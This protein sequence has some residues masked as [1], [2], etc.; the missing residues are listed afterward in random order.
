MGYR[1][2]EE[3]RPDYKDIRV[4]ESRG[5]NIGERLD[6]MRRQI[7]EE[8]KAKAESWKSLIQDPVESALGSYERAQNR[9]ILAEEAAQKRRVADLQAKRAEQ[10]IAL[11]EEFG[12]EERQAQL[13]AAREQ[14]E[15][16][17]IAREQ[18]E[19]R[20]TLLG[21]TVPGT[22]RTYL[23]E[24]ILAP[25]EAQ[26]AQIALSGRQADLAEKQAGLAAETAR[27]NQAMGRLQIDNAE[28][29]RRVED[30]TAQLAVETDP[31]RRQA[32][33]AELSKT[34]TA[35]E[36]AQA[37][38]QVKSAEFQSGMMKMLLPT[39][40]NR[41]VRSQ[42]MQEQI[43]KT[44]SVLSDLQT[45]LKLLK[46]A[47]PGSEKA[48]AIA[49]RMAERA[50]SLGYEK[51]A[52]DLLKNFTFNPSALL[53]QRSPIQTRESNAQ[54][55]INM[56]KRKE[57]ENIRATYSDIP[58]A[59][60]YANSLNRQAYNLGVQLHGGNMFG[61]SQITNQLPPVPNIYDPM[62]QA[63]VQNA[64][65]EPQFQKTPMGQIQLQ[66]PNAQVQ[67]NPILEALMQGKARQQVGQK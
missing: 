5:P 9:R 7:A 12:R 66:Q 54:E 6:Q 45:D 62:R 35:P 17:R 65:T 18:A 30:M 56:I 38:S 31:T 55:I 14:M 15:T 23:Q 42:Q 29:A 57:S 36:I 3:Y 43:T 13:D 10:E 39:E 53:Q 2:S 44:N 1:I 28:R 8:G 47:A 21:E 49:G 20:Q 27:I 48:A 37:M 46:E 50:A 33:A 34:A 4:Y 61:Q 41:V 24:S 64:N 59:V 52:Q 32:L 40:Q 51:E 67:A 22:E 19:A 11:S 16:A 26:R 63:P 58:Q 60:D 25:I